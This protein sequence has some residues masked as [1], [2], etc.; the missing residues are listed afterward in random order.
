MKKNNKKAVKLILKLYENLITVYVQGK[1]PE[2]TFMRL[3]NSNTDVVKYIRKIVKE[4]KV[5]PTDI[6]SET[7]K[8]IK[9]LNKY[10]KRRVE[11]W[12]EE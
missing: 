10:S 11:E 2:E 5:F 1:I 12:E 7:K 3:N 8:R 9:K 6:L 4:D